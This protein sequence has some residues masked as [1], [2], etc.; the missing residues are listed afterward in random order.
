M[1]LIEAD[2]RCLHLNGSVTTVFSVILANRQYR[3]PVGNIHFSISN[4]EKPG[5]C[6]PPG[7]TAEKQKEVPPRNL[8]YKYCQEAPSRWDTCQS[9]KDIVHVIRMK[10]Y[11]DPEEQ[12]SILLRNTSRDRFPSRT[13]ARQAN[14]RVAVFSKEGVISRNSIQMGH[15]SIIPGPREVEVA[16][17]ENPPGYIAAKLKENIVMVGINGRKIKA[18]VNS[19]ADFSVISDKFRRELKTPLFK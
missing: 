3:I 1:F 17:E 13:R 7:R 8:G 4:A 11:L 5:A 12:H 18:L 10:P 19:G 2:V 9:S 14:Q 6:A 16:I 15:L